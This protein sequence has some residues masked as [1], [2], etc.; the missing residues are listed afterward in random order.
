MPRRAPLNRRRTYRRGPGG[1][2][3]ARQRAPLN[4]RR[5]SPTARFEIQAWR[6][7]A[8]WADEADIEQDLIITRALL[9]LFDPATQAA[10]ALPV[11][12]S[13]TKLD[14]PRCARPKPRRCSGRRPQRGRAC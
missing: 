3:G 10:A 13:R 11:E 7:Q 5:V 1:A 2:A 14:R 9:Q 8:P 6:S 12:R 4:R